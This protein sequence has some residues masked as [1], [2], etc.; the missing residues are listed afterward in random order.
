MRR[1]FARRAVELKRLYDLYQADLVEMI[2]HAK[3]NKEY[4]YFMTIINALTII[5]A[6]SKYVYAVPLKTKT[7]AKVARALEPILKANGMKF[8]QTDNGK[9]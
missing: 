8:L 7:G 5:N 1:N 9:E 6:F 4:K 2:Q 3:L